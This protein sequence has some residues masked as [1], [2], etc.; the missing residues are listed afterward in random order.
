MREAH[1]AGIR[2]VMI[3]GDHP[4]TAARI[5]T[6]LGI[7]EAGDAHAVTGGSWTSSTTRVG[8]RWCVPPRCTP[9]SHPSTSCGSSTHCRS[10]ARSSR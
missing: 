10:S 7:V 1:R 2:T 5:A 4:V 8:A 3:T 9:A 6:D